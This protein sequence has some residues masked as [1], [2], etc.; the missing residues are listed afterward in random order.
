[1][2]LRVKNWIL[3]LTGLLTMTGWLSHVV[4]PQ[5]A[6]A[7]KKP[8]GVTDSRVLS[9]LSPQIVGEQASALILNINKRSADYQRYRKALRGATEED[10]LVLQLQIFS[11]QQTVAAEIHQLVDTLL[12]LEKRGSHPELRKQV[13]TIC[14]RVVPNLWLNMKEFRGKIDEIRAK[15]QGATADE[16]LAI[17]N[18]IN[19]FTQRLNT[20]FY[21]SHAHIIK[22][23]HLGMNV[24]NE[25]N[26]FVD[27]LT[28]RCEELS[29]RI[30]LSVHR[31]DDLELRRADTP[32][33]TEIVKQ[34][35][36]VK[37][38]LDTNTAGMKVVLMIMSKFNLDTT[39]YREQLV[40]ATRDISS[41]LLNT[42]VAVNL[43]SRTFENIVNW[44]VEKGPQAMIK[45]LILGFILFACRFAMR[46]VRAGMEKAIDSS[47]VNLSQLAR[48]MIVTSASNMV[49]VFGVLIAL[50]QIGISLGPLLA[51]LGVAGFIVGFALQDTLGN[52][53]AGM[54]ILLY[55]PYDM[56]DLV[57]MG[58]VYG[59]VDKMSLVSTSLLTLDN[60]TI[61]IPNNK[62]WGDVIKN[63]TAQDIRRVDMVFGISYSDDIPKAETIL[64]GILTSHDR[65]LENPEPMVRVHTLGESSVDFI[66]RPWVKVNDYWDVYWD[67]TRTVKMTFDAEGVSIPFPQRDVHIYKENVPADTDSL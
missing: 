21:I 12:E 32:E 30:K 61:V 24:E 10:R 33:N 29:G 1:M 63:V 18:D 51:G 67:V 20:F 16:R 23:K 8:A 66:V 57:E 38:S 56:G 52:F 35:I 27:I 6:A 26:D 45:V 13:E 47:N 50:S 28:E 14:R 3:I 44:F 37:K 55:R 9:E 58:G 22:M 11:L 25:R 59:K 49:M 2:E 34:L 4:N 42:G 36:A 19:K 17:E 31:I 53:A 64:S 5:Q 54:M 15:R 43:M 46:I 48:R 41:G 39:E 7:E 62:I 60:Q 65:I 40:T